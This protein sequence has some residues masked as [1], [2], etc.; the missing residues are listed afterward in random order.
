[1]TPVASVTSIHRVVGR[2]EG[3]GADDDRCRH[4]HRSGYAGRCRRVAANSDRAFLVLLSTR[5][6]GPGRS[7]NHRA[8]PAGPSGARTNVARGRFPREPDHQEKTYRRCRIRISQP[9][10]L[11]P[12]LFSLSIN[13]CRTL[14][15]IE[16]SD[17]IFGRLRP[18]SIRE[19]ASRQV[20]AGCDRGTETLFTRDGSGP[21][22]CRRPSRRHPGDRT[23]LGV[24]PSTARPVSQALTGG[25]ST[26]RS[27]RLSRWFVSKL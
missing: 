6:P 1:M 18:N 4:R 2:A 15:E 8:H 13:I 9:R 11:P 3:S 12:T 17:D 27:R 14:S 25:K 24:A 7:N 16:R 5:S 22:P 23:N 26:S 10:F 19:E 20:A 21:R